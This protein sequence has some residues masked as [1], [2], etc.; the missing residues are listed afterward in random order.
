MQCKAFTLI[1]LLVVIAIIA[2]LAAMLLPSLASAKVKAQ[3]M[4]CA[5]NQKQLSLGWY[6]YADD[7]QNRLVNN[8]GMGETKEKRQSW[9]NNVQDWGTSEDNTNLDLIRS[10]KLNPLVNRSTAI[11]KCPSDHSAADNGPRIRSMSMNSLVGDPGTMAG[12]YNPQFVQFYKMSTIIKPSGVF[13][14]IDEHPD[15]INDG[16]FMNQWS[17]MT[18]G[19]LPASYHNGAANLL[20]A[21]GHRESH[22]WQV[23]G[24]VRQP[25]KGGMGGSFS[26]VPDKDYLWLRDRVSIPAN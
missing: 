1:E 19:N 13:V 7:N 17:T 14:F 5:N 2:I 12:V 18:W 20:F 22:K 9:V 15:S 10:G 26:A 21:D 24:T 4:G 16:F 3:G 23:P 25:I 8:H 11:Y 6:M